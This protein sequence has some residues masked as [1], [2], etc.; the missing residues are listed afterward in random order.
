MYVVLKSKLCV[1]FTT[2]CLRGAFLLLNMIYFLLKQN[3]TWAANDYFPILAYFPII[4]YGVKLSFKMSKITVD[5]KLFL[6]QQK[7][8]EVMNLKCYKQTQDPL[9][10]FSHQTPDDDH[11]IPL[12]TSLVSAP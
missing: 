1:C 3:A 5:T 10:V 11:E 4:D 8:R 2:V 12:K 7:N 6:D 9:T